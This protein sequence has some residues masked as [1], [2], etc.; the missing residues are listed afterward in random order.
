MP[1]YTCDVNA[2]GTLILLEAVRLCGLQNKTRFYQVS[3]LTIAD[4]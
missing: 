3:R 1:M 2:T 4:L